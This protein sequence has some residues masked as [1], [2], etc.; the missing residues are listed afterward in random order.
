MVKIGRFVIRVA[1]A[2]TAGRSPAEPNL[3]SLKSAP[4]A[5]AHITSRSSLSSMRV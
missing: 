2:A 3:T 5:A 4:Y 1:R